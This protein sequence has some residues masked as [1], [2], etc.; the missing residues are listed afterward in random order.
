MNKK[1]TFLDFSD[2]FHLMIVTTKSSILQSTILKDI[3]CSPIALRRKDWCFVYV[4][5]LIIIS[6]YL[7]HLNQ[8]NVFCGHTKQRKKKHVF[9]LKIKYIC[10]DSPH[11]I[12]ICFHTYTYTFKKCARKSKLKYF[13]LF[14]IP[15]L[16]SSAPFNF[17]LMIYMT[18]N[19]IL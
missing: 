15:Q 6:Q 9:Q 3:L 19:S 12:F 10:R 14:L 18:V 1:R 16:H 17:A 11:I 4:F 13:D 5:V 8:N 2:F 7:L